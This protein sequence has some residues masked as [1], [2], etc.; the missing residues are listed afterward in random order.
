V[1]DTETVAA[2]TVRVEERG[3]ARLRDARWWFRTLAW[4][5]VVAL[6]IWTLTIL[7][8]P[9]GRFVFQ[10]PGARLPLEA[11]TLSTAVFASIFAYLRYSVGGPRSL[12][13]VS[14]AFLA[15]GEYH[16]LSEVLIAGATG[17]DAIR[18]YSWTAGRLL[19]AALLLAGTTERNLRRRPPER[20]LREFGVLAVG[21][22]ANTATVKI[23]T[24]ASVITDD[25]FVSGT[26][27]A[28]GWYTSAVTNGFAADD[29]T[30]GLADCSATRTKDSGSDE[31]TAVK[32]N[33]GACSDNAGNTNGGIDSAA[34]KIDT[35]GPPPPWR[36]RRER[37]VTMVGTSPMSPSV[38]AAPTRP[39]TQRRAR[40]PSSRQ[41]RRRGTCSTA[42]ARTTPVSLRT[43]LRSR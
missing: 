30:S 6:S 34:Y 9:A 33:S 23:D 38:R 40:L 2:R 4:S 25:G 14:L 37:P 19:M 28:N 39:A 32:I 8:V 7:F 5:L 31:G 12:L 27:G 41:L 22:T 1:A 43:R 3:P 42:R 16:V 11:S 15:L 35:T 36:S 20:P 17:S 24:H 21:L 10:W 13:F 26:A 29:A 18:L